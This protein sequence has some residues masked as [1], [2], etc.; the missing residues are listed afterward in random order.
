VVYP[1]TLKVQKKIATHFEVVIPVGNRN[2]PQIRASKGD[3][4]Q[5]LKRG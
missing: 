5:V 3:L 2:P 1:N 4:A